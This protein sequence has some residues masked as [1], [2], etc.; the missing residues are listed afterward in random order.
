MIGTLRQR[1][2]ENQN[3]LCVQEGVSFHMQEES[4]WMFLCSL[5]VV[6]WV[7]P[8]ESILSTKVQSLGFKIRGF[9]FGLWA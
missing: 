9:G 8:L 2:I 5:G 7:I 3:I 6:E 4:L 1:L